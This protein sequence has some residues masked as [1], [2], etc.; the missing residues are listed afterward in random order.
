MTR[1]SEDFFTTAEY[2]QLVAAWRAS[3]ALAVADKLAERDEMYAAYV[4][5]LV[6]SAA[7]EDEADDGAEALETAELVTDEDRYLANLQLAIWLARGIYVDVD[8]QAALARLTVAVAPLLE[9]EPEDDHD[10]GEAALQRLGFPPADS[11]VDAPTVNRLIDRIIARVGWP[12]TL[13]FT[14]PLG[15]AMPDRPFWIH[16]RHQVGPQ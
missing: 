12:A 7:G 1:K 4:W 2:R 5:Y 9:V 11:E 3:G 14:L 13:D 6:A 10:G 15:P 16:T 8:A